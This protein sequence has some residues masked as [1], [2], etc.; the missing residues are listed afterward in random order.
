VL[1]SDGRV[2]IVGGVDGGEPVATAELFDP[3]TGT[4]D[5]A[6]SPAATRLGGTAIALPDGRVLLTG[7]LKTPEAAA[8]A[9]E[10]PKSTK[11]SKKGK[12]KKVKKPSPPPMPAEIFDPATGKW[13][14]VEGGGRLQDHV[15]ANLP[16]GA[17]LLAGGSGAEAEIFSSTA[18]TFLVVQ[19]MAEPRAGFTA[20]SL[21]DGR[22]LIVGGANA[23]FELPML[24][25]FDPIA[26]VFE[27]T[28]EMLIPR[29]GHT[30]TALSDGRVLIAGGAFVDIALHDLLV[31]D[32]T[33]T[34]LQPLDLD[35]EAGLESVEVTDSRTRADIRAQY[36]SPDAFTLY[37]YDEVTP[38]G[39]IAPVRLEQWSYY[40]Q[41][42]ELTIADD[43]VVGEAPFEV[44]E[45]TVVEPAPYDPA[46]FDAYIG[47]EEVV[48]AAGLEEYLGGPA[49]ELVENGELYFAD[50][51]SWGMKD[52]ELRYL[53][54]LAL[55]AQDPVAETD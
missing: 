4:F 43:Q 38:D 40:E 2:L 28:G 45:G 22:V 9:K 55:A 42:V 29:V 5:P 54:A 53:E 6:T 20:T 37:F 7:E 10:K 51:L 35:S 44:E 33:D 27:P 47:L 21:P 17:V 1:L 39:S 49:N 16:E 34:S 36:G 26:G 46:A 14:P 32:P 15:A 13:S 52:G 23:G 48:A 31:F 18:G 25:V 24:E 41:G 3:A 11:K 19:P 30:A 50:R 8:P 12:K